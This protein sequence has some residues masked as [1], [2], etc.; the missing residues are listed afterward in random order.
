MPFD[1]CI[2]YFIE[3]HPEHLLEYA[4][5]A[6]KDDQKWQYLLICISTQRKCIILA[7]S[8]EF[9]GKLLKG[10]HFLISSSQINDFTCMIYQTIPLPKSKIDI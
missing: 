6:I 8:Q 9:Y 5:V 4:K 10:I 2:E 3:M 1:T 7:R